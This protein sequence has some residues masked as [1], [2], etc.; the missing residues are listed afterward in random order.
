V[1]I[2]DQTG[3]AQ[4]VRKTVTMLVADGGNAMIRSE[5]R[6]LDINV[7]LYVDARDVVISPEIDKV[8]LQLSLE[9]R[10]ADA[11]ALKQAKTAPISQQPWTTEIRESTQC[12][13]ENGKPLVIAQSADPFTDR[14]VTVEAKATILK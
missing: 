1:T 10:L 8:R 13:L 7:P 11:E 12:V 6:L 5:A 4:P 2:T 9:Y 14:K 3:S